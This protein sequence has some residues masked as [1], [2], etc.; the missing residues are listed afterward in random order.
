MTHYFTLSYPVDG[1][2]KEE[3]FIVKQRDNGLYGAMVRANYADQTNEEKQA[4]R[5]LL[6]NEEDKQ[7]WDEIVSRS[8][9]IDNVSFFKK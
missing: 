5:D 6:L 9:G 2:V 1:T 8:Q 3:T 4:V 7:K